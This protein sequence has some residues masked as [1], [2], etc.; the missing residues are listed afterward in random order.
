MREDIAKILLDKGL[1]A[2][3]VAIAG[4]FLN[5]ALEKFKA[6]YAY[7]HMLSEAKLRAYRELGDAL[8]QFRVH[9]MS[10]ARMVQ[11]GLWPT[12][13]TNGFEEELDLQT[14][15]VKENREIIFRVISGNILFL[16]QDLEIAV[17][18]YLE[19]AGKLLKSIPRAAHQLA[20]FQQSVAAFDSSATEL[21]KIL[22][23]E[24]H[25]NPFA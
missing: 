3:V 20:E 15:T 24:L 19:T 13:G 18:A 25:R 23:D 14:K 8:F 2:L 17:N 5:R 1:L 11:P 12:Q 6:Q 4:W 7:A 10:L 9:T 16:R 21:Q 22:A